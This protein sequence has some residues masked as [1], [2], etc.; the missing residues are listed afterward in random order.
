MEFDDVLRLML[1]TPP[2]QRVKATAK[3]KQPKQQK[4]AE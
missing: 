2:K 4:P 3:R 1:C